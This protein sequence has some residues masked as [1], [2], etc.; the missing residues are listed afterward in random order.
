MIPVD[1]KF[2]VGV[3]GP[4][5][6]MLRQRL[7]ISGDLAANKATGPMTTFSPTV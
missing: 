6:E 2:A 3:P 4:H 5:D 7:V 1:A